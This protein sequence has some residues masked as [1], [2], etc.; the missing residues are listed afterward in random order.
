MSIREHTRAYV[1]IREHTS[2]L[3]GL[4][5]ELL[6]CQHVYLRTSKA[7]KVSIEPLPLELLLC[8]YL[9]FCT[10]SMRQFVLVKQVK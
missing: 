3:A 8:Q 4:P 9:Y 7:S 10:S 2:L 6:L 1:S 5:L